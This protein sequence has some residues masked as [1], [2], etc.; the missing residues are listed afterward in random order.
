MPRGRK[1]RKAQASIED[2]IAAINA[3]IKDLQEQLKVKKTE[4]KQLEDEKVSVDKQR[5]LDAVMDSGKSIDEII[6][7]IK[8]AADGEGE[9]ESP[10][11]TPD[12]E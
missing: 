12:A 6:E 11:E 10:D 7:I 5:I 4:L 8:A 9:N 2:R 3:E 1:P